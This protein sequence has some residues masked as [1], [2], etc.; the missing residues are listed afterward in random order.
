MQGIGDK[1]QVVVAVI[2]L[3]LQVKIWYWCIF[4]GLAEFTLRY[5]LLPQLYLQSVSG[6][7]QAVDSL[8]SI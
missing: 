3:R 8:L 5:K 2:L 1:S 4:D 6:V 7:N